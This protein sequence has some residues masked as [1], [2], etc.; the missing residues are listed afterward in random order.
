V[1]G[2]EKFNCTHTANSYRFF[3]STYIVLRA[4]IAPVAM[5]K[6]SIISL[7]AGLIGPYQSAENRPTVDRAL[8]SGSF[9]VDDATVERVTSQ[10]D[11]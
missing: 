11:E 3:H 9:R 6:R 4:A 1:S 10:T 8:G 2:A 7:V 5:I